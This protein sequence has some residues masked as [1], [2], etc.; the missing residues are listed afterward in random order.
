[1]SLLFTAIS[2]PKIQFRY[3]LLSSLSLNLGPQL[4][5]KCVS[6]TC[7]DSRYIA[8]TLFVWSNSCIEFYWEIQR[9]VDY[10]SR[11]KLKRLSFITQFKMSFYCCLW[12]VEKCLEKCLLRCS[13]RFWICNWIFA[14]ICSQVVLILADIQPQFSYK[15]ILI[16]KECIFVL[17]DFEWACFFNYIIHLYTVH[18][19]RQAK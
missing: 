17:E 9:K 19:N 8:C 1:M 18:V 16:K 10:C 13:T 11:V 5:G 15:I 14:S 12:V 7:S 6:N 2:P 3:C 4:A